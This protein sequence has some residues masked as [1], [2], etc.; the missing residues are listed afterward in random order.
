MPRAL[1]FIPAAIALLAAGIFLGGHPDRLPTFV[2]DALVGG[3]DTR[4]VRERIERIHDTY[5]R[6]IPESQ[7]ADDSL[8]GI[9]AALHD[10]F[11]NYSTPKEYM[12]FQEI[13]NSRFSGIG[14]E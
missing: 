11:S 7:L 6:K 5:Y 2:S 8:K 3:K 4:V 14:L 1:A 9:V 13:S 12:Q 10:R